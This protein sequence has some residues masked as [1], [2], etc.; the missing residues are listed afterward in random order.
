MRKDIGLFLH[1]HS[2]GVHICIQ[3]ADRMSAGTFEGSYPK[4]K[5]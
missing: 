1:R 5:I 2:Q 4:T 3:L